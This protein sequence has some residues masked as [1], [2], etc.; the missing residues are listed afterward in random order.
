MLYQ[1]KVGCFLYN[2][3]RSSSKLEKA[4]QESISRSIALSSRNRKENLGAWKLEETAI[5]KE[6]GER[7]LGIEKFFSQNLREIRTRS[8][9]EKILTKFL[10][11]AYSEA[12]GWLSQLSV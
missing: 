7:M 5:S 1:R 8:S 4:H 2:H 6:E 3:L 11:L 10:K 12:P 9:R